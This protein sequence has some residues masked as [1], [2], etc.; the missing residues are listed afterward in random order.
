MNVEEGA[1]KQRSSNDQG[2]IKDAGTGT[3]LR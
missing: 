2:A 3:N 1:I